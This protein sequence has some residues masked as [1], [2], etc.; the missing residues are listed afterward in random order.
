MAEIDRIGVP[1]LLVEHASPNESLSSLGLTSPQIADRVRTTFFA[2][3]S[4][5]TLS[6][7]I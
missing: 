5:K 2:G 1:D 4:A 3:N 6:S 7:A